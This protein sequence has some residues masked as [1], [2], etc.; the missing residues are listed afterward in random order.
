MVH[1]LMNFKEKILE[2][3]KDQIIG[4]KYNSEKLYAHDISDEGKLIS[5]IYDLLS[6]EIDINENG[7]NF[8][9]EYWGLKSVANIILD[10]EE[11]D[12]DFHRGFSDP[13]EIV[14]WL[15]K[16]KQERRY[17]LLTT[18]E[19]LNSDIQN[20][21]FKKYENKKLGGI[22]DNSDTEYYISAF[23]DEG[24]VLD[25]LV[26]LSKNIT[27]LTLLGY[28]FLNEFYG[29]QYLAKR[30]YEKYPKYIKKNSKK[31][32][33]WLVNEKHDLIKS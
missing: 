11:W 10:Y 18:E 22:I 2:K 33:E 32:L 21:I 19:K 27:Y 8:L 4:T 29:F 15:K 6:H 13:K 30:L 17:R 25:F 3:Y 23:R 5:L 24:E 26:N 1:K 28:Y 16:F 31:N 7:V 20:A 14:K 12:G 9:E